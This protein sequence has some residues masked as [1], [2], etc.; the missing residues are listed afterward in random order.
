MYNIEW[1][2]LRRPFPAVEQCWMSVGPRPP[3]AP[4]WAGMPRELKRGYRGR[5][6]RARKGINFWAPPPCG[7]PLGPQISLQHARPLGG[8]RTSYGGVSFVIGLSGGLSPPHSPIGQ[9]GLVGAV[10]PEEVVASRLLSVSAGAAA[11][12]PPQGRGAPFGR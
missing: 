3:Q 10:R 11:P 8:R 5:W 4:P 12:A 2:S 6:P 1:R 7:P 9:L